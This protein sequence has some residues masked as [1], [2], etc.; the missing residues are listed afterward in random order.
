VRPSTQSVVHVVKVKHNDEMLKNEV[1]KTKQQT[2]ATF[3]ISGHISM[4]VKGT[5][6][7]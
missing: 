3:F 6:N 5:D 2:D 4:G 1:L 7:C